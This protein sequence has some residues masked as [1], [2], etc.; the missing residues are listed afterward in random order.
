MKY[1]KNGDQMRSFMKSEAKRLNINVS[2][3]YLTFISRCFLKRI[4]VLNDSNL[5]VK[6]SSASCVYLGQLIRGIVDVDI[7]SLGSFDIN[8]KYFMDV[9]RD[10]SIDDLVFELA[11]DP[12]ITPTGINKLSFVASYDR[13]RQLLNVDLQQNYNRLIEKEVRKMPAIFKND[14]EFS[15]NL[16][17]F[18]E[19]LCEKMCI[20]LEN[21]KTEVLNTR[22]KDFYDIY[23]LYGGNYDYDK[24]TKY[25]PKMLE[26]RGKLSMSDADTSFLNSQYIQA[27]QDCW[28][29]AKR[30]YDFLDKDIDLESAVYYG[31]AVLREELQKCN[32]NDFDFISNL[33]VIAEKLFPL[34]KKRKK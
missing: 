5:L 33:C 30:K 22:V 18:E 23:E 28:N 34:V 4:S 14:I 27:H 16:P 10:D 24:L 11:K 25:F 3:V 19:Y 1:F 21:N 12:I 13:M 32:N 29:K 2:T 15:L 31:R 7:A 26:M 17:S 9:L 6:G 20:I 8:S